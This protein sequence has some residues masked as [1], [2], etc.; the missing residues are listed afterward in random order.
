[1][2]PAA[3]C[4]QPLVHARRSPHPGTHRE[5]I[6]V[7][8]QRR[9]H[10]VR[11]RPARAD[12]IVRAWYGNGRPFF[13][14]VVAWT[15]RRKDNVVDVPRETTIAAIRAHVVAHA[16][17]QQGTAGSLTQR[18]SQLLRYSGRGSTACK[19]VRRPG[20]RTSL[21]TKGYTTSSSAQ[22]RLVNP[23]ARSQP[24]CPS[25]AV[26]EAYRQGMAARGH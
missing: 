5:V 24:A 1:M 25:H 15:R 12:R 9:A 19:R 14:A 6:V 16:T 18:Q 23:C 4:G 21:P 8:V 2:P 10:L 20:R 22:P 13:W 11:R 17:H 7:G 26:A 3:P